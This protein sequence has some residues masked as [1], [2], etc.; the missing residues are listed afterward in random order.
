MSNHPPAPAS[1][2]PPPN[3]ILTNPGMLATTASSLSADRLPK[4]GD[5]VLYREN[6]EDRPAFVGGVTKDGLVNLCYLTYNAT[7]RA[8][9][10]VS[11]DPRPEDAS[12][13]MWRWK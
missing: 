8:I 13:G 7:W 1:S 9:S 4:P 2:E 5:Q 10:S 6:R 3:A 11:R 12:P